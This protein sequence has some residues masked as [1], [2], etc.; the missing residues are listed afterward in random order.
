MSGGD[1]T[2]GRGGVDGGIIL[3]QEG[4]GFEGDNGGGGGSLVSSTATAA[5]T[6]TA[7]VTATASATATGVVDVVY[8]ALLGEITEATPAGTDTSLSVAPNAGDTI[9]ISA[10]LRDSNPST[11]ITA[12]TFGS[13]PCS[14]LGAV[15]NS[16]ATTLMQRTE[17]WRLLN[18]STATANLRVQYSESI[19]GARVSVHALTNLNSFGTATTLTSNST[20]HSI[21]IGTQSPGSMV[22]A[23]FNQQFPTTGPWTPGSGDTE[24][25]DGITNTQG[26]N[27]LAF[28]DLTTSA[29]ATGNVTISAQTPLAGP[30]SGVAVELKSAT[31]TSTDPGGTGN[32]QVSGSRFRDPNGNLFA[33][34]GF[35][36]YPNQSSADSVNKMKNGW[37][38]NCV[39]I[40]YQPGYT[41]AQ[42]Q[43]CIDAYGAE[44]MICL[45]TW[46]DGNGVQLTNAVR[47]A[48]IAALQPLAAAN[49]G[50]TLV[51]WLG[52]TEPEGR[53]S[54]MVYTATG[55]ASFNSASVTRWTNFNVAVHDAIRAEGCLQP[56][57]IGSLI[58]AQDVKKSESNT[59]ITSGEPWNELSAAI[60]FKSNFTGL[61][62][63]FFEIHPY[64][65]YKSGTE[66]QFQAYIQAAENAGI[67]L[68]LGDITSHESGGTFDGSHNPK[69]YDFINNALRAGL[70]YDTSVWHWGVSA[71]GNNGRQAL[72]TPNGTGTPSDGGGDDIN[73]LT[74][75][76]NLTD[77]T[78]TGGADPDSRFG[79]IFWDWFHG[80]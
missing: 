13:D 31:A 16:T 46:H 5:A 32:Y 44:G 19:N 36:I 73:S 1:L 34:K 26:Q 50:N 42:V 52:F 71:Q 3:I 66:T 18:P 2:L 11:T 68:S 69:I 23:A 64:G 67:L 51:W 63:Y 9:I 7:T 22:F 39:Q 38:T 6:T 21:T 43:A 54:A 41:Q 33:L 47:D 29:T 53:T 27:D 80:I 57:A 62:N 72:T 37:K 25:T 58:W 48:A 79:Q 56:Y 55:G 28:T 15:A 12:V 65:W 35:D 24:R 70:T 59:I 17:I 40:K 45:V 30:F 74:I 60:K 4:G 77:G 20:D 75:P 61:D 49:A 76:T 14:L 78:A 8:R 10:G